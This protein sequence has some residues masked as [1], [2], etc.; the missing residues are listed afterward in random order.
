MDNAFVSREENTACTEASYSYTTSFIAVGDWGYNEWCH[1]NVRPGC[2]M[3]VAE[4]MKDFMESEGDRIKCIVN[5]GDSFYCDGVGGNDDYRWAQFWTDF[6]GDEDASRQVRNAASNSLRATR[7]K[8]VL[9]DSEQV[10]M[11]AVAQQ[12]VPIAIEA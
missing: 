5:V 8:D 4:A 11:S 9:V 3:V 10:W 2:Q 7:Y 6:Y 1:G 12:H